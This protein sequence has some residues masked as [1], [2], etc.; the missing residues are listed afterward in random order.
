MCH[1]LVEYLAIGCC[2][3][4]P[5]PKTRLHVPLADGINTKYGR[6]D[7]SDLVGTCANLSSDPTKS[8]RIGIAAREY[9]DRFLRTDQLA[10]YYVDRCA[11]ILSWRDSG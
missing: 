9:Y 1:R 11:S 7:P 5:A 3:V 10:G 8:A 6:D 4:R 2:V